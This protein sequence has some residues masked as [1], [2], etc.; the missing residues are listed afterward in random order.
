MR[1]F[2]TELQEPITEQYVNPCPKNATY[3]NTTAAESLLDAI[4]KQDVFGLPSVIIRL[5]P[6]QTEKMH[7]SQVPMRF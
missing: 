2:A 4:N 3:T 1:F 6:F 7:F 5:Y